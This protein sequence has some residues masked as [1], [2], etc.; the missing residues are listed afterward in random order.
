M[1]SQ[2][3]RLI[4]WPW[5]IVSSVARAAQS[6]WTSTA[7]GCESLDGWCHNV[8]WNSKICM[9]S[10]CY[11]F[12][13]PWRCE[14]KSCDLLKVWATAWPWQ[15]FHRYRLQC[16]VRDS[17]DRL[18]ISSYDWILCAGQPFHHDHRWCRYS[19]ATVGTQSL[20]VSSREKAF[21]NLWPPGV[22]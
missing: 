15:P 3:L 12:R 16:W 21:Y 7:R 19:C 18:L 13:W 11:T 14:A 22:T 6:I 20:W 1:T 8:S 5:W 9:V 2:L 10:A 17:L 4:T